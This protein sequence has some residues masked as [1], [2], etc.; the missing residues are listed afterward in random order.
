MHKRMITPAEAHQRALEDAIQNAL[1]RRDAEWK[2]AFDREITE[3]K[4]ALQN[5]AVEAVQDGI[6]ERDRQ[7]N[8]RL[9]A[10]CNAIALAAPHL[11]VAALTQTLCNDDLN[12]EDAAAR[13]EVLWRGAQPSGPV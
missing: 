10:R 1:V 12:A 9:S 13:L 11:P 7:W 2:A 5:A 4:T 6:A 8:E 3:F